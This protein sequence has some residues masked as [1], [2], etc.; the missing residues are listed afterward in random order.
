MIPN[1][2]TLFSL[3]GKTA[4]VTGGGGGLGLVCAHTLAAAGARVAI[5]GRD[6]HKL[7]RAAAELVE[8]NA[9][10]FSASMD[11]TDRVGVEAALERIEHEFAPLDILVNNAGI[12]APRPVLEMSEQEWSG[13]IGTD[14][15]GVWRV[16]Q[17]VARR[18]VKRRAGAIINMASVLGLAVQPTQANYASAKAGVIQL[19][20]A[21]ARELWREGVRVNAIA[22]GYFP[23][24]MN[25]GFLE[26][27][28]G[29]AYIARLFPGRTGQPKELAGA[30]LLLASD[31][32]SYI[33]GVTLPVDGGILLAAP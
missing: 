5:A 9:Q 13:V 31:A 15:T 19:T 27:P 22:P 25:R 6:I 20:R 3:S 2:T 4:L 1:P 10:V 8:A 12:A 32:G 17:V 24:D 30:L 16:A 28:R 11:V 18:M 23:T 26:S 14:L 29:N 33:T 7:E 21:L